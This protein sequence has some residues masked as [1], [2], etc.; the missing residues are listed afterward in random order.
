[1]AATGQMAMTCLGTPYTMAPE[2]CTGQQYGLKSD[3]WSLGCVLYEL[4]TLQTA[5]K[6]DNLFTLVY[7][8]VQGG[9]HWRAVV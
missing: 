4:C 3:I 6:G 1:M 5:F 8:I 2:V 9:A 7:Q